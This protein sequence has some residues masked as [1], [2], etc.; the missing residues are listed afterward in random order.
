MARRIATWNHRVAALLLMACASN[1]FAADRCVPT[2]KLATRNYPGAEAVVPGNNLLLPAGKSIPA[3]GQKVIIAGQVR[4]K[5]CLPV[6]DAVVELWQVDPFGRL[7][8]AGPDELATPNPVF[9][10]AGRTTTDKNGQFV[11]TTAFPAA[12]A[13]RAPHV[14]IKILAPE[15][16]DFSTALFF[17]GDQ[18]NA[19]D[20]VYK[21][22]KPAGRDAVTLHMATNADGD[23]VGAT[24]IVLSGEAPYRVY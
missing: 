5:H 21:S 2:P 22:L 14:N 6:P 4:D 8:L 15:M 7:L 11:F 12:A 18:R 3:E 1:A 10:G 20:A 16:N 23:M 24:T 19:S 9:A 17:G 13:K